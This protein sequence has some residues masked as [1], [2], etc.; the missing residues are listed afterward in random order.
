MIILLAYLSITSITKKSDDPGRLIWILIQPHSAH[1]ALCAK[2]L[3]AA[4]AIAPTISSR[5]V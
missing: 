1:F 5:K 3:E 4:A 2:R